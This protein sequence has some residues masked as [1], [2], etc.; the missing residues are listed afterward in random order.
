[1]NRRELHIHI[2]AFDIPWPADYGG[3][4]DIFHKI[5]LLSAQGIR[6]H[7]HCFRYGERQPAAELLHYCEEVRYY[8][9]QT[10]PP[11]FFSLTPYIIKS[12]MSRALEQVL[13]RDRYPILCEGIHTCGILKN[14]R[15]QGRKIL[16]RPS[17]V[18]HDYYRGLAAQERNLFRKIFFLTEACKLKWWERHLAK[19]SVILPVSDKDQAWFSR[20]FPLVPAHLIY[21]F[22]PY[23][24]VDIL[25]GRGSY[26]LFHGKLSVQDN[27][28][29]ADYLIREVVPHTSLPVIIAG[30]DPPQ[31]LRE[32][33]A[34]TKGVTLRANPGEEEMER[35]IREAH[36]HL[37]LTFQASGIKL[38]LLLSLFRGRYIVV[39]APMLTSQGL[40][41][42]VILTTDGKD[43][44]GKLEELKERG[45]TDEEVEKRN[46]CLPSGYRNAHKTILLLSVID[47]MSEGPASS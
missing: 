12:R 5:R 36:V 14:K 40:E 43:L 7:L 8:E 27:A 29:V 37:M 24:E 31:W 11:A 26:A 17:N 33:A 19:V 13:L 46:R 20:R 23:D 44:A 4:I 15:L 32:L 30:M 34:R 21:S 2:I 45:F 22:T 9:R 10:G 47:A 42:C 38:K 35:L 16:F 25:P 39:N 18:E 3:V 1:M 28:A 41:E 6:I